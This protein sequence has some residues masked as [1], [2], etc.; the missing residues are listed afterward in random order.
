VPELVE[1]RC[2]ETSRTLCALRGVFTAIAKTGDAA[3]ARSGSAVARKAA[4]SAPSAS[5]AGHSRHDRITAG[6]ADHVASIRDVIGNTANRDNG[7]GAFRQFSCERYCGGGVIR[8]VDALAASR[9][10]GQ[11]DTPLRRVPPE[12]R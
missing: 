1:K 4:I 2:R 10:S 11:C 3:A 5:D 12:P 7:A 8:R 9:E 6:D